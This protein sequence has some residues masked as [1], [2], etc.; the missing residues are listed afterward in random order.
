MS[1]EID[2]HREIKYEGRNAR[3]FK[4][5]EMIDQRCEN[6][7]KLIYFICRKNDVGL[8]V[9]YDI[10]FN[11]KSIIGVEEPDAQGLQKPVF[12]DKHIMRITLPDNYPAI[13]ECPELKFMTDVWHPQIRYFG[14]FKGL[15]DINCEGPHQHL[16]LFIDRVI[17]YLKYIDYWAKNDYPYPQDW[18]VAQWVL[19]QAEPQGWLNFN[20]ENRNK[21]I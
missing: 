9:A 1:K 18:E 15:I 11:I 10:F 8:P 17:D 21:T 20:K 19:K 16:V 5:W 2:K 6:D 12:G 4:E 13:D 7:E 14:D 3:L